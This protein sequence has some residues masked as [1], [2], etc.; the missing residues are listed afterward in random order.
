VTLVLQGH[1]FYTPPTLEG[2]WLYT[3]LVIA[4]GNTGLITRHDG[5]VTD[6]CALILS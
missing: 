5:H 3:G 2:M 4:D 6:I 1:T